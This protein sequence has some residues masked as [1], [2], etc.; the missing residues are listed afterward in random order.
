MNPSLKREI[1]NFLITFFITVL[2]WSY[3]INFEFDISKLYHPWG[4]K[5]D[6][7]LNLF[8]IKNWFI[9]NSIISNEFVGFPIFEKYNMTN[10]P[11][12]I[13]LNSFFIFKITSV[14]TDNFILSKNIFLLIR[15]G[16]IAVSALFF[17]N[18]ISKNIFLNIIFSIIFSLSL[19]LQ[20]RGS[21]HFVVTNYYVIPIMLAFI[22]KHF[23]IF[24]YEKLIIKNYLNRSF[25]L[26]ILIFSF[27]GVYFLYYFII[28]FFFLYFFL[29]FYGEKKKELTIF[30]I[31]TIL[32]ILSL[33]L[34]VT[35]PH[36]IFGEKINN[37]LPVEQDMYGLK[38]LHYLIP[39]SNVFFDIFQNVRDSY[40]ESKIGFEKISR[41]GILGTLGFFAICIKIILLRNTRK[42][43]FELFEFYICCLFFFLVFC[44]MIGGMS[45]FQ[46]LIFPDIRANN[47]VSIYLQFLAFSVLLISIN[48]LKINK[49]IISIVIFFI[50]IIVF[51][52]INNNPNKKYK[53]LRDKYKFINYENFFKENLKKNDKV[54]IF[55]VISKFPEVPF[56]NN[57]NPYEL[58][59]P[60]LLT[61]NVYFSYP[62]LSKTK[63]SEWRK[64]L[65]FLSDEDF[66]IE[67][68]NRN[69]NKILVDNDFKEDFFRKY[70]LDKK[71]FHKINSSNK[72]GPLLFLTSKYD[73]YKLVYNLEDYK[74]D[75]NNDFYPKKITFNSLDNLETV[76]LPRYID[77]KKLLLEKRINK[78]KPINLKKHIVKINTHGPSSY[79]SDQ[80]MKFDI[81]CILTK[82]KN[83]IFLKIKNKS[84]NDLITY[85]GKF[86]VNIRSFSRDIKK[87]N[88]FNNSIVHDQI[89]FLQSKKEKV[90]KVNLNTKR[91]KKILAKLTEYDKI[92]FDL[93][94][95][96]N[97]WFHQKQT[98]NKLCI[99]DLNELR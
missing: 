53:L 3:V 19:H 13:D 57:K 20:S 27:G 42:N 55:P 79:I 26:Y 18:K 93:V 47:R 97:S 95:E 40:S 99:L 37:R 92:V 41:F 33:I 31:L 98:D 94:Q 65:N 34:I 50:L 85:D 75:Y 48:K 5:G 78:N 10:Y 69:F 22:F 90:V 81:T 8:I 87:N 43:I 91:N 84:K 51:G 66:I 59:I 44:T 15:P 89:E 32:I 73:L 4:F 7:L 49:N 64:Y 2:L 14:F 6:A 17:F 72:S 9:S 36:L 46:S 82:D 1:L 77:K 35:I 56:Y 29:L 52:E 54:L 62:S 60:Y 25:F 74:I 80:E 21:G 61:K 96:G 39:P 12:L 63:S 83:A 16:I 67:L 30:F 24:F 76:K 23:N 70:K 71:Y 86:R 28:S 88:V 11:F 45:F 38:L 68:K 58:I